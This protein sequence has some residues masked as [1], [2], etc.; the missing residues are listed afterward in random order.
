MME[1]P[2]QYR[3]EA[4]R[5]GMLR[6]GVYY[7][8]S[9]VSPVVREEILKWLNTI[10]PLWEERYSAHNPPPPGQSQR[11]LLRPVYWL[12]NW[13]FACLDYYHPPKGVLNRCVRAEPFPKALAALVAK[14]EAIAR[15][16]YRGRTCQPAGISIPVS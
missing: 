4:R 5:S 2:T 9:F 14:A 11:R 1:T 12:G 13:Q 3:H 15:R 8:R 16:E 7:D 6:P 10:H